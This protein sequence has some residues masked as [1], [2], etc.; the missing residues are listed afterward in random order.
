MKMYK[1]FA[2][3]CVDNF[4]IL[5]FFSTN[6]FDYIDFQFSGSEQEKYNSFINDLQLHISTQPI[7]IDMNMRNQQIDRG[8]S[9]KEVFT[10]KSVNDFINRLYK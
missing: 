9:K 2:N 1:L 7:Y 4:T 8:L 3:G 6:Y 10:I 5:Y